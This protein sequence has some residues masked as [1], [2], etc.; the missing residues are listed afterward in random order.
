MSI[1][2]TESIKYILDEMDP[3]EKLEFERVLQT[4]PDLLIEVESIKRME[5]KLRDLPELS[6]PGSLTNTVLLLA[7]SE[8]RKN[9]SR[10]FKFYLSAA[11]MIFGL[12]AGSMLMDNPFKS[13]SDQVQASVGLTASPT[14]DATEN[15]RSSVNELQP[16]VDRNNVLHLGGFESGG[17]FYGTQDFTN[18]YQ[19]LRPAGNQ[20]HSQSSNRALHLT[21]SNR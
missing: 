17:S 21:G 16:W 15:N 12:T 2:D 4:N 1:K 6:P 10:N 13:D 5:K 8:S 18:S 7:A 19:R 14:V 3:A 11:V 20:D 9:H